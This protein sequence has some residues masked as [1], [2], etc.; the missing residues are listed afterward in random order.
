M[1]AAAEDAAGCGGPRRPTAHAP[2]SVTAP[3]TASAASRAVTG[4]R[5][6]ER[7]VPRA[8]QHAASTLPARTKKGKRHKSSCGTTRL[9]E[10]NNRQVR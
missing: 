6:C 5:R 9:P 4:A 7:R 10:K 1:L 2:V 8:S 3:R